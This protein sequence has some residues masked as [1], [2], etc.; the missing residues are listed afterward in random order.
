MLCSSTV[1]TSQTIGVLVWWAVILIGPPLLLRRWWR[2]R[3]GSRNRSH[4]RAPWAS[5]C[6]RSEGLDS[7]PSGPSRRPVPQVTRSGPGPRGRR[8]TSTRDVLGVAHSC[9][10]AREPERTPQPRRA[11]DDGYGAPR[12]L[13][14]LCAQ[15]DRRRQLQMD[16]AE[17][18]ARLSALPVGR[19][20]I[21][22]C[23]VAGDRG[24]SL[25]ILG[26]TGVFVVGATSRA[27]HF[28][29]LLVV[30]ELAQ[31]V[32]S[33]LPGYTGVVQAAVC[34]PHSAQAP[35][36]WYRR[37]RYG[38][39]TRAWLVGGD[40][41]VGWLGFFGS[42]HGLRVDDLAWFDRLVDPHSSSG[43]VR[44]RQTWPPIGQPSDLNRG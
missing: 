34:D 20:R 35:R 7:L 36:L 39:W 26:E 41:I 16:A 40:W 29:E 43:P 13:K 19:W 32:Q 1:T 37:D 28:D 4:W 25:L 42:E 33:L 17:L 11:A 15:V 24:N 44:A 18:E 31:K 2:R 27:G 38:R 22:A 21:V 12:V 8:E 5:S 30:S 9:P 14:P 3:R 10:S 23:P 6:G